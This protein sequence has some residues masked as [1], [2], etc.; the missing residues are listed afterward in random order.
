MACGVV[1]SHG[2]L[3]DPLADLGICQRRGTGQSRGCRQKHSS[4][5]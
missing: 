4:S 1:V 2:L 3:D 5:N